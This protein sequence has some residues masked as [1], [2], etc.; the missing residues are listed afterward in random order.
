MNASAHL[1]DRILF[2]FNCIFYHEK[3][4]I[5]NTFIVLWA[6][7]NVLDIDKVRFIYHFWG[8][9]GKRNI[10][11]MYQYF[12][13][14]HSLHIVMTGSSGVSCSTEAEPQFRKDES[15]SSPKQTDEKIHCKKKGKKEKNTKQHTES[16]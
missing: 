12:K 2:Q 4:Y 9:Y 16:T 3:N 7:I 13:S 11:A 6:K 5:S 8:K 15:I 14:M 10:L 1:D